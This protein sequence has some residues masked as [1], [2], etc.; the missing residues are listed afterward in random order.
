MMNAGSR[1]NSLCILEFRSRAV[2]V[3]NLS[4]A[5]GQ[6]TLLRRRAHSATFGILTFEQC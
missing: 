1:R 4:A 3:F 6:D 5:V 2:E